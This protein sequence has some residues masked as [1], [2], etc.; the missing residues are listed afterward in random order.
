LLVGIGFSTKSTKRW[1]Q[2]GLAN[3]ESIY[4]VFPFAALRFLLVGLFLA[5]LCGMTVSAQVVGAQ[6]VG[7][8]FALDAVSSRFLRLDPQ[9]GQVVD[10]FAAPVLCQPEGACGLAYDGHSLYYV[11]STDPAQRIYELNP[12]DGVIWNSM[13]APS[14]AIDGLA[15]DEGS[16]YA[17]SFSEDRI[18]R[19]SLPEGEIQQV[20][21]INTSA[22]GGLA[23]DGGRLLASSVLSGEIFEIDPQNGETSNTFNTGSVFPAG[24]TLLDGD[25]YVSDFE[26][27]RILRVDPDTGAELAVF[28]VGES[29][30]AALASGPSLRE[31]TYALALEVGDQELLSDG[32]V[33]ITLRVAVVDGEGRRLATNNDS[34]VDFGVLEG[35]AEIVGRGPK[36][37]QAGVAT[38]R[39]RLAIGARA[40]IQA[41]LSDDLSA[42]SINLGG[43][44]PAAALGLGLNRLEGQLVEVEATVFDA[45]GVPATQDTNL[46]TFSIRRGLGVVVG[47]SVVRPLDGVARTTVALLSERTVL[48]LVATM[49]DL[50]SI[51]VLDVVDDSGP[52]AGAGGLTVSGTAAGGIDEQPPAP[53]G[54]IVAVQQEGRV[55]LNWEPSSEDGQVQW[56]VFNGRNIAVPLVQDYRLFRRVDGGLYEFLARLPA[57]SVAFSDEIGPEALSYRYKVVAGDGAN[58]SETPIAPGSAA[59]DDRTVRLGTG[60]PV[61]ENGLP[62]LGLFDPTDLTVDFDDFFLFADNFGKSQED[63]DFDPR[64]DLNGNLEV[65]FAD[66]FL[67]ADNFG[68]TAVRLD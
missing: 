1:P 48:E 67:F 26:A 41:K 23:A 8:L 15:W 11:D 37:T 14:D 4:M 42:P 33:E 24:L 64:F 57:G 6:E 63:A 49:R 2:V 52:E 20:I 60:V 39:V 58:L 5:G 10:T 27:R 36:Q 16:L 53:P 65:D 61:D 25:L 45:N 30:I 54:A 62:V 47:A 7:Q 66:F 12:R 31:P 19:L 59:D 40:E 32:R 55:L 56:I 3:K 17:L 18:Y 34:Q 21:E 38:A 46:V 29:E 51:G 28:A 13:P 68:R 22:I 43:V 9:S 50:S 44:A 35:D